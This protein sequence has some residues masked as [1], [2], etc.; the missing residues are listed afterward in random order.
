MKC[1]E[2][3]IELCPACTNNKE[4]K[5]T[6][7]YKG[8]YDCFLDSYIHYLYGI[9][10]MELDMKTE[11]VALITDDK[12]GN[13]KLSYPHLFQALKICSIEHHDWAKVILVLK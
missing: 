7:I 3:K 12:F 1:E 10:Q 11:L 5:R 6:P 2:I 9:I 8:K 13:D 4:G